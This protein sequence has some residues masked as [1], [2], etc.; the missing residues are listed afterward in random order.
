MKNAK[1]L[2]IFM[3]LVLMT[4]AIFAGGQQEGAVN[5]VVELRYA[6]VHPA[7]YP[8]ELQ[9]LLLQMKLQKKQMAVLR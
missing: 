7:S 2:T 9:Q 6:T 5:K 3:I 8:M 1:I 4:T